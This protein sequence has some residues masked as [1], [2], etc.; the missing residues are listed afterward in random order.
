MK[1]YKEKS[2]QLVCVDVSL[3]RSILKEDRLLPDYSVHF[4]RGTTLLCEV[5]CQEACPKEKGQW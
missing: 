1:N 3:F 4:H 2:V 5:V